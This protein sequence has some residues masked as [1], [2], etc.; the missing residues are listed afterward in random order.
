MEL[1][2]LVF[3]AL[4]VA[5]SLVA[6]LARSRSNRARQPLFT[7]NK[8]AAAQLATGGRPSNEVKTHARTTEV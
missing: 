6:Q 7:P 1:V 4:L 2:L 5:I 3:A 8:E